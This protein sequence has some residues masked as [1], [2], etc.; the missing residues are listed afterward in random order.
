MSEND[1][2]RSAEQ[3]ILSMQ[4]ASLRRGNLHNVELLRHLCAT[5]GMETRFNY[6]IGSQTNK[7]KG[8]CH[9]ATMGFEPGSGVNSKAW[10]DPVTRRWLVDNKLVSS[11]NPNNKSQMMWSAK[12]LQA[13]PLGRTI[14]SMFED[15]IRFELF[16]MVNHFSW[17]PIQMHLAFSGVLLGGNGG[18]AYQPQ[19][20]SELSGWYTN[21]TR[22]DLIDA[23]SQHYKYL[24]GADDASRIAWLRYFQTGSKPGI[25]EN[26]YYGKG[27]WAA[28]GG[29]WKAKYDKVSMIVKG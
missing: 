16:G 19:T 14:A 3:N 4:E 5:S 10:S 9:T 27:A 2:E 26:Y 18:R 17:G 8:Q 22:N 6:L 12:V 24:P 20:W 15:V 28:S 29:G 11:P 1:K 21:P 7:I 13:A 25:A 23:V